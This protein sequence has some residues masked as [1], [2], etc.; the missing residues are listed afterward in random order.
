MTFI[1]SSVLPFNDPLEVSL[2]ECFDGPFNFFSVS[3]FIASSVVLFNDPN[4]VPLDVHLVDILILS[5]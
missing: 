4:E 3:T 2:D 1:V 5:P